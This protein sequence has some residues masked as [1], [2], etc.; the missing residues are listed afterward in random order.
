MAICMLQDAFCSGAND[1]DGVQAAADR[2]QVFPSPKMSK[3]GVL[4]AWLSSLK[5][6]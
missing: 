5:T 6:F 1:K 2:I 3:K 4:D